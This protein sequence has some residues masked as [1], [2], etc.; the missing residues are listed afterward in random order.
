MFR[1]MLMIRFQ[2]VG[3]RNDAAFRLVVT[4][5]TTGPKSNKHVEL[6]GSY[7][8]KTKAISL[9]NDRIEYWMSMGAQL[10]DRVHNLLISQGVIEGKKRNALPKKSPIVKEAPVEEK[11]K[12]EAAPAAEGAEA[13]APAEEAPTEEAPAEEAAPVEEEKKVEEAPV[14][15]EKKEEVTA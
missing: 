12:E 9:K 2:R 6:L 4:E 5:H 15:E 11:K 7:N 10:S 1:P 3:R 14:E 13:E 8:P